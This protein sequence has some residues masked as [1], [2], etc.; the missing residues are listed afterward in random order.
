MNPQ[1]DLY[2]VK[3]NDTLWKIARDHNTTVEELKK[4][5]DIKDPRTLHEGQ[6]LALHK[7][8]VGGF[9]VL[10]LDKDRNPIEKLNYRLEACDKQYTGTTGKNGE[11]KR[12]V[13]DSPFNLVGIWVQRIDGSWKKAATAISGFGEKQ[14]VLVSGHMMVPTK[15]EKHPDL[16]P[17]TQPDTKARPKPKYGPDNPPKPTTDKEPGVTP[18]QTQTPDGKPLT[19]V[20]GDLPGL[21][22][23]LELFNGEVMTDSD[24]AWA[25]NELDV[26]LPAIKAFAKVESGGTKS[27]GF[28]EFEKR[29]LPKILYERHYFSARTKHQFSEKY[30]DISLPTGYYV[31]KTLYVEANDDYKKKHG[32]PTDVHYY[33]PVQKK[34]S[35]AIKAKAESLE[36]MLKNGHAIDMRDKY[37]G[38]IFSYKRL[39]K[40]YQLDKVAALESCSWGA[41]QIMG[42]NWRQMGYKSIYEFTKAMSRSEKEQIK[43][44]VLFIKNVKPKIV[45][46][47][48]EKNWAMA[49]KL[50]NGSDYKKNSYDTKLAAAYKEYKEEK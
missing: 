14:T 44:F 36:T 5:N 26:E 30:P 11:T 24:Y 22:E 9:R 20:E 19:T 25:A 2:T 32:V 23:F 33:R 39:T 49:A 34:D 4:L 3:K 41:F 46:A 16:P 7:E 15:T 1:R 21:D 18:K 10:F 42:S 37:K 38:D 35:I 31:A 17:N 50:Y 29:K 28:I 27:S 13:T 48:K 47:L 43:A 45:V 40:A 12:I 6:Q 8:T